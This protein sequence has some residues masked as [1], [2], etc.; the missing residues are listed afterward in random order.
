MALLSK[1]AEGL[2]GIE[3][4]GIP[5]ES[6]DANLGV[7]KDDLELW[8]TLA[9]RSAGI[10]TRET[11]ENALKPFAN[12]KGPERLREEDDRY[13]YSCVNAISLKDDDAG[14]IT[15]SLSVSIEREV[16]VFPGVWITASVADTATVGCLGA[17]SPSERGTASRPGEAQRGINR[18]GR[19]HQ[20][21]SVRS[22]HANQT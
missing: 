2:A 3:S 17:C 15:Y 16:I 9:I 19:T 14:Q 22:G 21:L 1:G 10:S 13:R 7:S 12:E 20:P 4:L 6:V 5:V 11:Q 8:A 18:Q